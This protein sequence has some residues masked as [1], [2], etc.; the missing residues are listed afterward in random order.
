M[1][2]ARGPEIARRLED[3]NIIVNYQAG[4]TEEGFTASGALRM[5][6]AEMTPFR[7]AGGGYADGGPADPRCE[8]ADGRRVKDEVTALRK[9]FQEMH[10]CFP[11]KDTRG[12]CWKGW[13]DISVSIHKWHLLASGGVLAS[14]RSSA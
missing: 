13:S 3:N 14:C 7:H 11:A 2:Y 10:F 5:G 1:G 8:W 6:V 9:Q 12:P 4:P